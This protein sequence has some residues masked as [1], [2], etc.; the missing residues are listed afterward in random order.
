MRC[1]STAKHVTLFALIRD[2]KYFEN[3]SQRIEQLVM[4][5]LIAYVYVQISSCFK[6]L[7]FPLIDNY[8]HINFNYMRNTI[9]SLQTITS[10]FLLHFRHSPQKKAYTKRH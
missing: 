7:M 3:F 9:K 5:F 1:V 8:P 2:K 10:P 4:S 6:F